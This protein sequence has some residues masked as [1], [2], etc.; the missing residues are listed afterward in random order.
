MIGG[1]PRRIWSAAI[2]TDAANGS[3]STASR[4]SGTTRTMRRRVLPRHR[5]LTFLERWQSGRMRRIRNPVYGIAVTWVRIPPSP[6]ETETPL[7]G[8]F[9]FLGERVVWTNPPVRRIRLE[10]IR[11]PKAAPSAARGEAHGWAEQ[12]HP[13]RQIKRLTQHSV[14]LDFTPIS[15]LVATRLT[16]GTPDDASTS[17]S[18]AASGL[19][20]KAL[21][22]PK[23]MDRYQRTR[24]HGAVFRGKRS[25]ARADWSDQAGI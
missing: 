9:A 2:A 15:P 1:P 16:R 13:L 19:R 7:V 12:S 23:S 24:I 22:R 5:A 17:T 10:R 25:R 20:K 8:R 11:T 14:T 6:P 4:A 21:S 3:R 18:C